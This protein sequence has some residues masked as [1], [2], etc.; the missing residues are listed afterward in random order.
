MTLRR[1][2][3]CAAALTTTLL[4][5][6]ALAGPAQAHHNGVDVQVA[7]TRPCDEITFTSGWE[8]AEHQVASTVV[9]VRV[10]GQVQSAPVGTPLAAGPFAEPTTVEWRVWGGGERGY[11]HPPLD[12]LDALLAHLAAGGGELDPDTPGVAW[13]RLYVDGCAGPQAPELVAAQCDVLAELVVPE[14]EGVVYSHGSGPLNPG[15]HLVTAEP[16]DGWAFPAD[17][18]AEWEFVV[19]AVPGCPGQPGD[20][21]QPGSDGDDGQDGTS[22]VAAG[23]DEQL[24]LTGG[25]AVPL[26]LAG[27]G[28]LGV[29][30]VAVALARRRRIQ[31]AAR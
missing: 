23:G 4:G 29:G 2:I 17:A 22:A 12:D 25:G 7:H 27:S 31:F 11:D 13:H 3:G 21:G 5:A 18:T 10:A 15:V 8:I 9:V 1:I 24:P 26:A 6:L 30:G 16:A 14:V 19:Q 20:P 28:L